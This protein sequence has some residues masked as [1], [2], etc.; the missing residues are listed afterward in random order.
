MGITP[1]TEL[2][3]LRVFTSVRRRLPLTLGEFP[4]HVD[5]RLDAIINCQRRKGVLQLGALAR[6][7]KLM[8]QTFQ[9][10]NA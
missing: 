1:D 9:P 2:P 4:I 7:L 3:G 10:R 5:D 8:H 6:R